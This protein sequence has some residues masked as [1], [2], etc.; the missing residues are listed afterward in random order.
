MT[1]VQ[2]PLWHQISI[3]FWAYF[4][5]NKMDSKMEINTE[6]NFWNSSHRAEEVAEC[7]LPWQPPLPEPLPVHGQPKFYLIL[8]TSS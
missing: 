4:L 5:I 1:W 3:S 2:I 7:W 6:T 8:E